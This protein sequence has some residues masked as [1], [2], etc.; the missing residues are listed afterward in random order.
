LKLCNSWCMAW[1]KLTKPSKNLDFTVCDLESHN[2]IIA[3]WQADFMPH[4][5]NG[6]LQLVV[7]IIQKEWWFT[8]T[9]LES[10]IH[11]LRAKG[12]IVLW[13]NCVMGVLWFWGIKWNFSCLGPYMCSHWM[14]L[15]V[16]PSVPLSVCLS[17]HLSVRPSVC[18]LGIWI[19]R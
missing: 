1:S 18:P 19:L 12:V 10:L 16:F 14:G 15:L 6:E 5:L 17:V 3:T 13:C 9:I 11:F 8:C 2:C 4:C 7:R